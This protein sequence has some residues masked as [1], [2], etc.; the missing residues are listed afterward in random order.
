MTDVKTIL[1]SRTV[2]ANIVGILALA[3]TF[4]GSELSSEE[5]NKLVEACLQ[6]VAA[7]S[8]VASTVFRVL[9]T[10]RIGG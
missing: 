4:L 5:T 1:E 10:T 7:G 9:A 3:G 2:W 6:L 8:F